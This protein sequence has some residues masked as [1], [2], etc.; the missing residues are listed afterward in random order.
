MSADVAMK[1]IRIHAFSYEAP[2]EGRKRAQRLQ[3]R[4]W[5][6]S[7]SREKLALADLAWASAEKPFS[8]ETNRSFDQLVGAEFSSADSVQEY[9]REKRNGALEVKALDAALHNLAHELGITVS[10][11]SGA[12]ISDISPAPYVE[13]IPVIGDAL[14]FPAVEPTE[15]E[16]RQN[17][18]RTRHL[19]ELAKP[20]LD[21]SLLEREA[22]R[23]GLG[24]L[25]TPWLSFE[26]SDRYGRVFGFSWTRSSASSQI[27]TAVTTDKHS[28]RMVLDNA[29]VPVPR[30]R[31]FS[32]HDVAGAVKYAEGIGYPV[33][34]KPLRGTGGRGV[35][36]D[37]NDAEG[38]EWAFHAL[39]DTD[40]ANRD[41]I[42]EEHIHGT[43][44]RA[45][46]VGDRVVSMIHWPNGTVQGNGSLTV[47]ELLLRKHQVRDRNPHLMNRP[48]QFDK[49]TEYKL[50]QQGVD[51]Q[52]V[53]PAG[54]SVTFSMNPN[55]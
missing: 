45:Y 5:G 13:L 12:E 43:S 10:G 14:W 42:V 25:R 1:V 28:T 27:A 46:V 52:T 21:S 47:E 20:Q 40:Y 53:L 32:A 33:V 19:R 4:L 36:T 54:K 38:L 24:T 11:A 17:T 31:R 35:V 30:G 50:E 15:A 2:A 34:F 41:V 8:K 9:F 51:Y 23:F 37:I 49:K 18:Y 44:G 22:L 29:G 6:R 55:P 39:K 26:A 16:R 7:G 3:V 48:I